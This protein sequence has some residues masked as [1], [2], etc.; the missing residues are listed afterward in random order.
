MFVERGGPGYELEAEAVVDHG[1]P[2]R[3]QSQALAIGSGDVFAG[4]SGLERKTGFAGEFAGD[5]LKLPTSQRLDQPAGEDH[6]LSLPLRQTFVRQM[7]GTV[8]HRLPYLGSKSAI[9]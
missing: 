7:I 3:S 9:R 5:R 8:C 1:E 4:L 6:T 2:A